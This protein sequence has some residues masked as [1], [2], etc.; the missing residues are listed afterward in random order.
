[1]TALKTSYI[2]SS[3]R[4]QTIRSH[5]SKS[6]LNGRQKEKRGLPTRLQRTTALRVM[7]IFSL[8]A[9]TA[10]CSSLA[11]TQLRAT[12]RNVGLETYR[13]IA[14][15]ATI[16]AQAITD[17]KFKGSEVMG[18]LM[19]NVLP[20]SEDWPM[21]NM[22]GYIPISQAVAALSATWVQA[23]NVIVKPEEVE[24]LEN[25]AKEVYKVQKRPNNTGYND[26][27]FGIWK[28]DKSG[29]KT[30]ADGRLH[31]TNG[32][33]DWGGKRKILIP[34]IMHNTPGARSHLFNS[35]SEGDRAV[36]IDDAM[37][38]AEAHEDPTTSPQCG[39]F[40]DMVE[41]I[42]RHNFNMICL[43]SVIHKY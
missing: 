1:M 15:S 19:S 43:V 28:S 24:A 2:A 22:D 26:F 6:V 38:C 13:S 20:N 30:Y 33:T 25:H 10:I 5:D 32:E 31:D 8:I 41:L 23:L 37:D 3:E 34:L 7:L 21:I 17:R 14:L 11:Y 18:K 12:E 39:V 35:Y 29:N 4:E 9:A 16:G 40:T 42:V 27:G 36:Y